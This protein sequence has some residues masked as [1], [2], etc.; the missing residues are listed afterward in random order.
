VAT[1]MA[2]AATVS[3]FTIAVFI[4]FFLNEGVGIGQAR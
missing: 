4:V 3:V 2:A 1:M